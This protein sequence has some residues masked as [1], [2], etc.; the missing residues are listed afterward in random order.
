MKT[1]FWNRMFATVLFAGAVTA[2]APTAWSAD[3]ADA[4]PASS[5]PYGTT[6]ADWSAEWVE[7]TLSTTADQSPFLDPD[8][9]SC[10]AGQ[11]PPVF[12]LGSN[13]GGETVRKCAVPAGQAILFSAGGDFCILGLSADTEDGLNA[14]IEGS[15]GELKTARAEVDGVP[16]ALDKHRFITKLFEFTLPDNNIF[17][18]PP[19]SYQAVAGGYFVMLPPLS[20]G[21]HVIRFHTEFPAFSFVSDVTYNLSVASR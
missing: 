15:L 12:F 10:A 13:F 16:L 21:E 4:F 20:V 3:R 1:N 14:C 8:G 17:G 19:G 9:R 5:K 2:G 6:Y 7:W 11:S 18:L